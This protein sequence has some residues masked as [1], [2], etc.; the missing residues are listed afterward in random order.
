MIKSVLIDVFK[1]CLEEMEYR[2]H[3]IRDLQRLVEDY[4]FEDLASLLAKLRGFTWETDGDHAVDRPFALPWTHY[5]TLT[6]C[7]PNPPHVAGSYAL[8]GSLGRSPL[9]FRSGFRTLGTIVKALKE[10]AA[11]FQRQVLICHWLDH[12]EV[13]QERV[14]FV[15]FC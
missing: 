6:V 3:F 15:N 14:I 7:F 9:T 13:C 12:M 8:A 10:E 5:I 1:K 2:K 11:T 4:L